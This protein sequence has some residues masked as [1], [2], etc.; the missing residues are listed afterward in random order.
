[1]L[2]VS[3]D[4]IPFRLASPLGFESSKMFTFE[5]SVFLGS[6]L[7]NIIFI[8]WGRSIYPFQRT[9]TLHFIAHMNRGEQFPIKVYVVYI[10]NKFCLIQSLGCFGRIFKLILPS[11]VIC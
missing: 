8:G 4:N 6:K 7:F 2:R 11:C 10:D 1:M 5:G 9:Q 3:L